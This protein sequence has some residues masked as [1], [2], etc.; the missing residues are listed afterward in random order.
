MLQ[1]Q[2]PIGSLIFH[3]YHESNIVSSNSLSEKIENLVDIIQYRTIHKGIEYT[4]KS[5]YNEMFELRLHF[6]N[7]LMA[8]PDILDGLSNKILDEISQKYF[9][10]NDHD[11]LGL[12][13]SDALEVYYK[14]FSVLVKNNHSELNNIPFPLEDMPT[15]SGF[16]ILLKQYPSKMLPN[17]IIEFLESSLDFDYALLLSEFVFR[18]ELKI[19]NEA[20]NELKTFLKKSLTKFGAYCVIS[21]YWQPEIADEL[22][23][24]RNI[25]IQAAA[26]RIEEGQGISYTPQSLQ[27]LLSN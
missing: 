23:L 14:I 22:Q 18:D 27:H 25:K 3:T 12:L 2:S 8:Q 4:S 19:D 15:W 1:V 17:N 20:I 13:M 11:G 24:I 26:L 21:G 9:L 6:I 7:M 5:I 16:K 10:R